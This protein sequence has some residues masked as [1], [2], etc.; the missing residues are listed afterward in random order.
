MNGLVKEVLSDFQSIYDLLCHCAPF[1]HNQSINNPSD[2]KKLS[3]KY[4]KYGNV[5]RISEN[6]DSLGFCAFYD[7]DEVNHCA[8]LSM[9]IVIPSAQGKGVAGILLDDMIRRCRESGMRSISLEVADDNNRA[10]KFYQKNGF[11][12]GKKFSDTSTQYILDIS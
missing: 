3:E 7:N 11:V 9:I 4:L 8:F 10:I 1:F 5:I 12:K 2:I 6:D